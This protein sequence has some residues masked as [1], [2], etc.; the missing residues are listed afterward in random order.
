[1][2]RS[3]TDKQTD[4]QIPKVIHYCWF[5]KGEKPPIV[6]DCIDSW[7]KTCP[8]WK[9]VEWNESNF[10][11]NYYGYT[12]EAYSQKK[13][14]FVSDVARL[15]ILS[16]NGGVYLDTDVELKKPIQDEWLQYKSFLFFEF[17]SRINT[18]LGFGCKKGSECIK[19]LADDYLNR[20]FIKNNGSLNQQA[21]TYYN[22][23]ALERYFASLKLN[24]KFQV[25]DGNAF[26][27]TGM[28]NQIAC[29]HYASSWTDS[30]KN[31]IEKK[32]EWKDTRIKRFLRKPE[33]QNWVKKHLGARISGIYTFIAY[34]L[35][36]M[37]PGFY[38]RRWFKKYIIKMKK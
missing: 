32:R 5:G 34:D 36:E 27:S 15:V 8:E 12:K 37:G 16:E 21:C 18:G 30:P 7:K 25:I 17:E 6:R 26:L 14:A 11:V 24:D 20:K 33:R 3:T 38:L 29:H 13:W 9:I 35:T 19:Y 28:Y 10:D 2:G 1:M 23:N 22:T 4:R 31:K